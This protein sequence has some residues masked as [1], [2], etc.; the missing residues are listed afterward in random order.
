MTRPNRLAL[1]IPFVVIASADQSFADPTATGARPPAQ[2]PVS[3]KKYYPAKA[4]NLC[5]E[6]SNII[7]VLIGAD[8]RVSDVRIARS[9]G[10][11]DLDEAS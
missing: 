1:L 3:S 5:V 9:S 10:N 11:S 7:D 8:G 4:L 2:A 6:A